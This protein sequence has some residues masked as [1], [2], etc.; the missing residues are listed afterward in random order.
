MKLQIFAVRDR[1]TAQYGNPMFLMNTGHAIRSFAD[2]INKRG[3][4]GE[5]LLNEHP[6][7][8]DLYNL[9]YYETDTGIFETEIPKQ[10]AIG[11]DLLIN[12]Q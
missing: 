1:A 11:K 8:F 5:N 7:D 12:K 3:Q 6:E 10:I 2:Q 9:G 4:P